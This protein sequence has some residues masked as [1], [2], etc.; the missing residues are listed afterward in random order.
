MVRSEAKTKKLEQ[1]NA[2]L[3]NRW[4]QKMNQEAERMNDANLFIESVR[5][6]N[7]RSAI[8]KKADLD[9]AMPTE[10]VSM[11]DRLGLYPLPSSRILYFLIKIAMSK[12][13]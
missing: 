12:W 1:E 8:E 2:E 6:Q 13:K 11:F 10:K 3:V 7:Q 9:A 5:Q 4:L